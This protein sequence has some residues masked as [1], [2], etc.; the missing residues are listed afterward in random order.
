MLTTKELHVEF[1]YP[2]SAS[3]SCP[4]KLIILMTRM[5]PA[6]DS[7]EDREGYLSCVS[8]EEELYKS[9]ITIRILGLFS[10]A[11]NFKRTIGVRL[12]SK[13]IGESARDHGCTD[14]LYGMVQSDGVRFL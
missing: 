10:T 12:M 2:R 5:Q 11:I 14:I 6:V 9:P 8:L 13:M 1:R 7:V 4:S 3:D